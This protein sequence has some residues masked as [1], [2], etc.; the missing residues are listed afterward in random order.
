[1]AKETPRATS[2]RLPAATHEYVGL[3]ARERAISRSAA[4]VAIADEHAAR[5]DILLSSV[6]VGPE[7]TLIWELLPLPAGP[8]GAML[9]IATDLDG[10]VST[11]EL[12]DMCE[13]RD[14]WRGDTL[15]LEQGR[16]FYAATAFIRDVVARQRVAS[17]LRPQDD[18]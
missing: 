11:S 3:V 4:Y 1:M 2:L 8:H 14:G 13:R 12:F 18:K 16:E 10:E 6:A 9:V 17:L 5:L 7:G 15:P